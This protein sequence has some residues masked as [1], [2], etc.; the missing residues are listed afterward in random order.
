M[1][2][3]LRQVGDEYVLSLPPG[4]AEQLAPKGSQGDVPVEVSVQ[5]GQVVLR[6]PMEADSATV[7]K[8]A[9]KVMDDF[10]SALRRL[11]E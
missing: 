1:I 5:D 8:V 10:D 6:P 7:R 3:K 11:A 4:A 2:A 9:E